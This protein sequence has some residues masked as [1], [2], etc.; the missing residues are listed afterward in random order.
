MSYGANFPAQFRRAAESP[1]RKRQ[2]SKLRLSITEVCSGRC[3]CHVVDGPPPD[4]ANPGR[5]LFL[6]TGLLAVNRVCVVR[7][8]ASGDLRC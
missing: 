5:G 8:V 4:A 1:W 3:A 2:S 7:Y 6:V